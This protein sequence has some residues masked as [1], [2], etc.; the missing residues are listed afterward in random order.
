M[1]VEILNKE[2]PKAD[3]PGIDSLDPRWAEVSGLA[4]NGDFEEC[5]RQSLSLLEQDI[6]DI[7][8][9]GY[10][11]YGA[12]ASDGVAALGGVFKALANVL[13]PN[14]EAVGPASKAKP[15]QTSLGWFF[16]QMLKKVQREE[17]AKG[18]EWNRWCETTQDEVDEIQAA[19]RQ[20]LGAIDGALG[21]GAAPVLDAASKLR[22]WLQGFR[23]SA[24][25]PPPPPAPEPEPIAEEP[26][27]V[28]AS[29][30]APKRAAPDGAAVEG[31]YALQQLIRKLQVFEQ[32][33]KEEKFPRALIVADDINSIIASFDPTVYFPNL[34]ATFMKLMAMNIGQLAEFEGARDSGDWKALVQLYRVDLDAFVAL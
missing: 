27:R 9:I 13:G 31:S 14:W 4:Q 3:P 1:N 6:W 10:L 21:E 16:K 2:F 32:L 22:Q 19:L 25:K 26:T 24:K 28:E 23:N 33:I 30:A 11:C 5:A 20:L 8:L 7:R 34:F 12:F 29:A 18:A 15:A 17:Q